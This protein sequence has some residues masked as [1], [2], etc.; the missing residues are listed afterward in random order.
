MRVYSLMEDTTCEPDVV[1]EHGLSLYVMTAHHRLLFDAGRSGKFADNAA[2]L[3]INP[4]DVDIAI[5][6]HGHYDHGNGLARFL[7]VNDHAQIYINR[8]A[9]GQYYYRSERYIGIDP[10]V[11]RTL[12][13]SGRVV[14]TDDTYIIDDELSLC[15][16][17]DKTSV[18]PVDNAGLT[19]KIG[20]TFVPDRF[21]HEQYLVINDKTHISQTEKSVIGRRIVLSGCSHKGILNI[22]N[23]LRP[24]VLIGG[25]HFIDIDVSSG[26]SDVLNK[27]AEVLMTAYEGRTPTMFYTC[28]CTG[29]AQYSYL[30]KRMCDR[31]EYLSSGQTIE[32]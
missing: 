2:K 3:G 22:V 32:I 24:D 26:Y 11:I 19:E 30:K 23:W 17:N 12:S 10:E 5:L 25:F 14:F 8:H 7:E 31:L 28:H 18:F 16:C 13:E 21:L 6:S 20:D 29:A 27:A 15:T 1:S 4:A 9:F